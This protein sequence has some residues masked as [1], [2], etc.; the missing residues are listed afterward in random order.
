MRKIFEEQSKGF[1]LM[2]IMVTV[3]IF[4]IVIFITGSLYSLAQSS[5][6][7][8]TD[9]MELVQNARVAYDRI[10]REIRQSPAIATSLYTDP[11]SSTNEIMFQNGHDENI[12]NYIYYYLDGSDLR[13]AKMVYYFD[14]EPN[15][16]VRYNITNAS[17]D[18][19]KSKVIEDRVVGEYFQNIEFWG[20]NGLVHA[21]STLTKDKESFSMYSSVYSRN[22]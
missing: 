19:P 12:I 17:G 15:T 10:S 22:Y 6:N 2:E 7:T 4:V 1:T 8:A 3:G 18:Y 16:H 9:E 5:Y 11:A 21:S 14:S 20:G 13:R